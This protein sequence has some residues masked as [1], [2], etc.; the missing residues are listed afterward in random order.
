[1]VWLFKDQGKG[2][3]RRG[4]E[5]GGKGLCEPFERVSLFEG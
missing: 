2:E 1:M 3:E 4:E 5:G